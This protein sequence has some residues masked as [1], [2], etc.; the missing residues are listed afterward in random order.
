LTVVRL[1]GPA[2]TERFDYLGL[3]TFVL[4]G[5]VT[6][7]VMTADPQ[8]LRFTLLAA[9]GLAPLLTGTVGWA[10][11]ASDVSSVETRILC[12]RPGNTILFIRGDQ[13]VEAR[14]DRVT[15]TSGSLRLKRWGSTLRGRLA[16][17]N[18]ELSLG[19]GHVTGHIADRPIL[20]EVA[21][22]DTSLNVSGQFGAR[23][24]SLHLSA[25]VLSGDIG[26]CS[27]DLQFRNDEY[28]GR[29]SCGAAPAAVSLRVPAALI[30][31]S[32]VELAAMLTA[33]LAR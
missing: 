10:E 15:L 31:R 19:Q 5:N 23:A 17:Q 20:L 28:A 27:Y 12:A 24:I 33:F 30:A 8:K 1:H 9:L 3:L 14:V 13:I 25:R 21:R 32:D 26:P 6:S 18:L 22:A 11:P 7:T 4:I 29:V 2:L 16:S